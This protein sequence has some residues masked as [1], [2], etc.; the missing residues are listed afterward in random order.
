MRFGKSWEEVENEPTTSGGGYIKYFKKGDTTFRIVQE[1][2]D[3]IGYW[4]HYNPG[5]FPFPCT[6]DRKT[7]PGCTSSN[8][9]MKKASRKIAINVLEGEYVNVYKFPKTLADK[10]SNRANR[11][12]TISDRDYTISRIESKNSDGSTKTDYDIEGGDKI[13]VD[14]S[15]LEL[16]DVEAMLAAAYDEAWG[17]SAKTQQNAEDDQAQTNLRSKLNQATEGKPED[18]PDWAKAEEKT[19]QPKVWSEDELRGMRL[20]E[21]IKV[22]LN[23]GVGEPPETLNTTDQVV[24]WLLEQ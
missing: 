5:G 23:E 14:L 6:G 2:K 24:D 4:E 16:K 15:K 17:D 9:K 13:P 7:C 11:I 3:W 12:G 10:L 21:I 19:D 18:I 20:D 1:P 8:E 22:C